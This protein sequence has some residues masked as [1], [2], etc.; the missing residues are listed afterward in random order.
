MTAKKDYWTSKRSDGKWVVKKDGS[1]KASSLHVTQE[2]AWR[3]ARR[4]ARGE[5]SEAFLKGKDGKIRT[6]NSYGNDSYPPKG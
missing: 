2:N 5:G 3:E 6:R 1:S 4:L